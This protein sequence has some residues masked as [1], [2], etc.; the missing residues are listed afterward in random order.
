ML[1]TGITDSLFVQLCFSKT[2]GRG[3]TGKCRR[4]E[5]VRE[6][7]QQR[8]VEGWLTIVLFHGA[9]AV[10]ADIKRQL[11][12]TGR[13]GRLGCAVL[14]GSSHVLGD[15]VFALA[16]TQQA[17]VAGG[18]RGPLVHPKSERGLHKRQHF[19]S[20]NLTTYLYAYFGILH[21]KNTAI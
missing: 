6:A 17:T 11:K 12:G 14:I 21:L 20:F 16:A 7:Y 19:F 2:K 15:G 9:F 5:R 18:V 1:I 13:F 4:R 3:K 8:L 10:G